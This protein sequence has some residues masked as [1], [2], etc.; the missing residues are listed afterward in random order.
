MIVKIIEEAGIDSAMLG[1][2]LNKNQDENM[3]FPVAN[4]LAHMGN[5]HS[6]F[7]ES[8]QVWID[9][10]A[11]LYFWSQ[12]DTYR[13]GITKQSQSKMHTITKKELSRESFESTEDLFPCV[14]SGLNGLID[15]YNCLEDSDH[16]KKIFRQIVKNIPEDFLQRRVISTNYKTLQ[17]IV[18]Q[19]HKHKLIEWRHFCNEV[20]DGVQYP[21]WI[22]KESVDKTAKF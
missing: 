3:M 22:K 12:F 4:K 8:V 7:L 14:I 11:P 16:K 15:V 2:S 1:L 19:R 6:K 17:N 21:N 9:V 18:S 5:G 20:L 10:T 13:I